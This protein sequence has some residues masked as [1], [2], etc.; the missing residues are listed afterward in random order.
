MPAALAVSVREEIV[1][2]RNAGETFQQIANELGVSYNASRRI[3]Q[4]YE[5][6]G[7]IKPHYERC[8]P[9][10]VRKGQALYEAAVALKQ[11]HRSW[12]AGL[13]RLEMTERFAAEQL[14]SERTLQR[15]FRRAGVGSQTEVSRP[16][17]AVNRGRQAHQV[18]AMDAKE[19]M[20]LADGSYASWLTI[21]DEASGAVLSAT[22]FPYPPVEPIGSL[23][24]QASLTEDAG[25]VGATRGHA[26][27]QR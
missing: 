11:A 6:E 21:T 9:P 17:M 23:T 16:R 13:I 12:G 2:R 14:P 4:Q 26:H 24:G 1:R 3:W 25:T 27:G 20:R 8:R 10:S 22:L 5:R 7:Q 15:W 19:Q 18:W